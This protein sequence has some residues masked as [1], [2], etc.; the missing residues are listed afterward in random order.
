MAHGCLTLP[1][2]NV[3]SSTPKS[4]AKATMSALLV[5]GF[6]LAGPALPANADEPDPPD[7]TKVDCV[8]L[9]FDD[10]PGEHTDRLLDILGEHDAKATF[11][12]L[13]SQVDEYK[14]EV[15][16]MVMDGHE[17]GSH[18]W[19]H[20][21]LTTLS[22]DEI[23][24]DLDRTDKAIN[25][26]IDKDPVT[27]R[28]PYGALNDT[29]RQAVDRPIML[30]DVD[31]LDWQHHN[32]DKIVDIAGKETSPGSVL[33]LHDIHKTTVDA[34]PAVLET[35]SEDDYEFVTI[36]DLFQEDLEPGTVYSDAR[37]EYTEQP[38]D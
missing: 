11:Y 4:V 5:G 6:V 12:L 10:G 1:P 7:C 32:G 18:S 25:N 15:K 24:D 3:T 38:G 14:D 34:V 36:G 13:G 19:E 8:A 17:I 27:V 23:E 29:V 16:R 33:L 28:P 26:I 37:S 35:L 22:T 31:T 2:V 30:W 21:D 9:T 20:A